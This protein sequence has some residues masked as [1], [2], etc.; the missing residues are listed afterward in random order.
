MTSQ[1]ESI[2]STQYTPLYEN[3]QFASRSSQWRL[4]FSYRTCCPLFR[5][6]SQLTDHS[7]IQLLVAIW[8]PDMSDNRMPTLPIIQYNNYH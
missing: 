8:L 3:E 6:T 7:A 2:R 1:I 4:L 5:S